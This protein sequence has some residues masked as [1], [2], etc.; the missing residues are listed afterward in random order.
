[1]ENEWK[2]PSCVDWAGCE[3]EAEREM[4]DARLRRE[5]AESDAE[6]SAMDGYYRTKYRD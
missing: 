5:L 4:K 2:L 6:E 1:M 3:E